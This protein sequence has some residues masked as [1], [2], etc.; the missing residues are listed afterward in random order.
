M[1]KRILLIDDETDVLAADIRNLKEDFDV[2]NADNGSDAMNTIKSNY[3]FTVFISVLKMP[4]INGVAILSILKNI[5]PDSVRVLITR[6]PDTE[7]AFDTDNEG[8][9]FRF[10]TKPYPMTRLIRAL[11]E[12]IEEY[13]LKSKNLKAWKKRI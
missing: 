12:C 1:N 2:F 10:L 4:G 11:K 7:I 13:Y 6:H 5:F 9:I 8:Q 3:E